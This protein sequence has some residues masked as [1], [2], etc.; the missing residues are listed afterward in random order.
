MLDPIRRQR[1]ERRIALIFMAGLVILG[2]FIQWIAPRRD[3]S[4]RGPHTTIVH[5]E[6][7][8]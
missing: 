6:P 3:V 5:T 8:P 7:V 2:A 4:S 1:L